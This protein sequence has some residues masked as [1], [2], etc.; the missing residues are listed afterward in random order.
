MALFMA[1]FVAVF[2]VTFR[3]GCRAREAQHRVPS[4]H[5]RAQHHCGRAR[6][7]VGQGQQ[8]GHEQAAQHTERQSDRHRAG[9]AGGVIDQGDALERQLGRHQADRVLYPVVDGHRRVLLRC[10]PA[11]QLH[12]DRRR[13]PRQGVDVVHV[14]ADHGQVGH[15]FLQALFQQHSHHADG[16]QRARHVMANGWGQAAQQRVAGG[17]GQ[18]FGGGVGLQRGDVCHASQAPWVLLFESESEFLSASVFS[19]GGAVS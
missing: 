2:M 15:G 6:V 14:F 10:Q 17:F 19:G 1:L 8:A 13:F 7:R 11:H 3:R 18:A 4:L 16:L 5:S 12:A 9:R